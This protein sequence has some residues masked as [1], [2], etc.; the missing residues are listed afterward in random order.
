MAL[1]TLVITMSGEPPAE[2][3][4]KPKVEVEFERAKNMAL[5]DISR[6]EQLYF[7]AYLAVKSTTTV[8]V[9]DDWLA[10]VDEVDWKQDDDAPLVQPTSPTA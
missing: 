4:I 8:K 3:V 2:Y 5:R 7:L 10:E 9:F 1:P 6:N